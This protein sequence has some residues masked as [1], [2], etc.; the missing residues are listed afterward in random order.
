MKPRPRTIVAGDK[1]FMATKAKEKNEAETAPEQAPDGPLLDLT[2]DSVKKMLR[3]AKKRGYEGFV[4]AQDE[5]S[6]TERKIE[7]TLIPSLKR[8]GISL[9]PYFPLGGGALTGKYRKGQALP[10]GSRHASADNRFLGP[11]WD[12]IEALHDFAD[13]RGHTLLELAMSWLACQPIVASII[14]GATRVEQ[15]DLN[16]KSVNWKLTDE[17]MAEIDKITA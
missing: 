5:L 6:L 4:A 14:A 10:E 3:L 9:V 16:A 15:L 13:K 12:K 2:A 11:N 8:N 7:K 17:E 1:T